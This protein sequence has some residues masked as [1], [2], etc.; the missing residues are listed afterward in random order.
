VANSHVF[1]VVAVR[2]VPAASY[3]LPLDDTRGVL[4]GDNAV[5]NGIVHGGN[6]VGIAVADTGGV[7]AKW[8]FR[9]VQWVFFWHN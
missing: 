3:G 5:M 7:A 2:S 6:S 9:R 4:G 1:A 8:L